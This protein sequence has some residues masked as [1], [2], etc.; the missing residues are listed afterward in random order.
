MGAVDR[1]IVREFTWCR[2][3]ADQL[4][5]IVVANEYYHNNNGKKKDGVSS[6]PS[7]HHDDD[8]IQ[9]QQKLKHAR[10]LLQTIQTMTPHCS[11]STNDNNNNNNSWDT[12]ALRETLDQ[13]KQQVLINSNSGNGWCYL[14][15][16]KIKKHG[17]MLPPLEHRR[18]GGGE[19]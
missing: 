11:S 13:L 3:V 10:A 1:L 6:W 7:H 2:A 14:L 9:Q 12:A 17:R 15:R 5:D 18:E 16:Q 4:S 19:S 8:P